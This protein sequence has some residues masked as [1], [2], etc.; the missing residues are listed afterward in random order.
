MIPFIASSIFCY[1]KVIAH[2]IGHDVNFDTS[3][4][5]LSLMENLN[6][7][8]VLVDLNT[9]AE[10]SSDGATYTISNVLPTGLFKRTHS[11]H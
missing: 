1:C 10:F 5:K 3:E 2:V 6:K 7:S 11:F 4:I 8:T 9:T